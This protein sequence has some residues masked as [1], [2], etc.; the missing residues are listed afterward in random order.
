MVRT[1]VLLSMSVAGLWAGQSDPA[2][3]FGETKTLALSLAAAPGQEFG[4]VRAGVAGPGFGA[5]VT[6]APYSAD[7]VTERVQILL[8]GNRVV[9][10]TSSTVARD[11]QGRVRRDESLAIALPGGAGKSDGPKIE[12]IDDPVAGIHWTLE[13]Q[14][15]TALKMTMPKR[16]SAFFTGAPPLPG[17]EKTWFYSSGAPGS[18]IN[19]QM[20]AKHDAEAGVNVSR[21][22]LGTRTIEGVTAQGTR[23]T[24]T[25]PAGE[26]GN[27]QPLVITSETWYSPDLKVLV[28]SKAEDPRIGVTTY[29][30][31]N[32]NRAEPAASL[33]EVPAGYTVTDG[34]ANVLFHREIRR[35]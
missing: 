7:A 33:F 22:D 24:R 30:L 29:R 12:T 6:G 35:E 32:I 25:I 31:T 26:V 28:L 2:K 16:E 34:P 3:Q 15:K 14:A 4:S 19:I 10:T 23:T 18:Q 20:L 21:V 17:P 8:D 13:S 9:Q 11:S 1:T 27:E 5:T